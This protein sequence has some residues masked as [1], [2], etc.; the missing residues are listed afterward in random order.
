M[1]FIAVNRI[2]VY[3]V[4]SLVMI[5]NNLSAQEAGKGRIEVLDNE[6]FETKLIHERGVLVDLRTDAEL[7]DGVIKGAKH[8]EWPG[9]G[10]EKISERFYTMEP[11]FL[12]CAGGYRSKEAAAWLIKKG[13]LNVKILENG[14]DSWNR[15]GYAIYTLQ[16]KMI[17]EKKTISTPQPRTDKP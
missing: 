15:E 6:A 8:A 3:A 12:Y 7:I 5:I 14:F 10:F 11:V 13:F 17:R 2:L 9:L 4:F 16:G 1:R